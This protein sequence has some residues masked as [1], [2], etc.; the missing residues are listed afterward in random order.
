MINEFITIASTGDA[1]D[2]GDILS[3]MAGG[4]NVLIQLEEY[5]SGG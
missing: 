4:G 3:I 1:Q 2:F 5:F